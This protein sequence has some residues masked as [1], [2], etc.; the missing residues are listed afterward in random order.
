MT[1]SLT[2]WVFFL[3]ATLPGE[4]AVAVGQP[5]PLFSLPAHDGQTYDLGQMKGQWVL[6][7]FYPKDDT[8][9]C[10]KQACSLRDSWAALGNAGVTVVGVSTDSIKSHEKFAKKYNLPFPL[11]SDSKKEVVEKYDVKGF[12][13]TK[14][15]SFLIDPEGKVAAIFDKVDVG[16]HG[17]Q[18]L[19]ALANL[20]G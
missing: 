15:K 14:R 17:D 8:P 2:T 16:R 5:A 1:M 6:V 18:V 7:Y 13:F 11:L 9:G 10:T 12:F 4:A 3:S 20:K 19:E